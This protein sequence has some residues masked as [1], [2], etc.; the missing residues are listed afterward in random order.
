MNPC[1]A[2]AQGIDIES[3]RQRP[4]PHIYLLIYIR[5][6]QQLLIPEKYFKLLHLSRTSQ[7]EARGGWW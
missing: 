7:L 4:R 2:T 3:L 6:R 1:P 5:L